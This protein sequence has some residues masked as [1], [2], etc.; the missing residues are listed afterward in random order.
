MELEAIFARIFHDSYN[1]SLL[2]LKTFHKTYKE[3]VAQM[4]AYNVLTSDEE[5]HPYLQ[6][7][8]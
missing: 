7:G 8:I 2:M 1:F 6:K 5:F 4:K 3:V